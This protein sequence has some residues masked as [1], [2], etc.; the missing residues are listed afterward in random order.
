M[1]VDIPRE[2]VH[3]TIVG[4]AG[5]LTREFLLQQQTLGQATLL[6]GEVEQALRDDYAEADPGDPAKVERILIGLLLPADGGAPLT[7]TQAMDLRQDQRTAILAKQLELNRADAHASET[8]DGDP[9]DG[10]DDELRE[11]IG[12]SWNEIIATLVS[13]GHCYEHIVD[14]WR[15]TPT[16]YAY[17]TIQRDRWRDAEL[18]RILAGCQPQ[19]EPDFGLD[20]ER[21]ARMMAAHEAF[22]RRVGPL[23]ALPPLSMPDP[24]TTRR[25]L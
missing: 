12:S 1:F 6:I 13:V 22:K 9:E 24:S 17:R 25:L 8:K 15:P 19:T 7:L 16:L 2:R 18:R 14:N 5:T 4:E 21:K 10:A 23:E 20:N 3:I 11:P